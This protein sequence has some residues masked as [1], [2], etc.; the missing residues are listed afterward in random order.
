MKILIGIDGS[1]YADAAVRFI[2]RYLAQPHAQVDVIHVL[3]LAVRADAAPPRQEREDLR[4][5]A[6]SRSLL[7]RNETRLKSRGFKVSTR[8]RRGVPARLIPEFAT[9]G[10]YDLVVVGAKGRSDT[11]FLQAG[12]VALAVLE[13]V[14]KSV[15]LVRERFLERNKEIPATLQPFPAVFATDGSPYSTRA[16]KA[17]FRFFNVP[18]LRPIAIAVAELPEN[19]VLWQMEVSLRKKL[20]RRLADTAGTW[21]GDMKQRLARPGLRPHARAVQGRATPGIIAEAKRR[22]AGLIVLGSRGAGDYW[23]PRLGSVGLQVA[24]S[25][26]C[27][28]LVVRES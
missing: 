15:L 13:H 3:P 10:D 4:I 9:K 20:I 11:P 24:R 22:E 1:R 12:S 21:A 26:P 7:E 16:A 2:C 14:P 25:A 23:G 5:P 6:A 17:F 27:S 28:V 19:P 18:E 8:V